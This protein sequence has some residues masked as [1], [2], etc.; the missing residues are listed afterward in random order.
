MT[1]GSSPGHEQVEELLETV[2]ASEARLVR[3]TA[4]LQAR[5]AALE[6]SNRE[7]EQFAYVASHDLTQPL[8]VIH[9]FADLLEDALAPVATSLEER[10]AEVTV[11]VLPEVVGDAGQLA[12]VFRNLVLNAAKFVPPGSKPNVTITAERATGAWSFS[13]A[14]NG[15]GIPVAFRE[16]VFGMFERLHGVEEYPGTG[17]GLAICR[18]IVERHGGRI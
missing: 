9:G 2:R 5:N 3:L 18:K 17:M 13:V 16:H 1:Q 4:E 8:A 15:I 10:G 14:D 11:G 12:Q 6:A 7:L